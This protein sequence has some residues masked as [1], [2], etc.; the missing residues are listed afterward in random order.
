MEGEEKKDP[1]NTASQGRTYFDDLRS[2]KLVSGALGI[3][4]L[5]LSRLVIL[6]DTLCF[7]TAK[8]MSTAEG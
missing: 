6:R 7:L 5:S 1:S 3:G 8:L 2:S 4:H